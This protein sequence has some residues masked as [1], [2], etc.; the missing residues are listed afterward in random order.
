MN[1]TVVLIDQNLLINMINTKTNINDKI[2]IQLKLYFWL[3]I[4]HFLHLTKVIEKLE[5]ILRELSIISFI[6]FLN[7]L[8]CYENVTQTVD[9]NSFVENYSKVI[10]F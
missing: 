7:L 9:I 5:K 3:D 8:D 6:E 10:Y 4:V 1:S 2:S